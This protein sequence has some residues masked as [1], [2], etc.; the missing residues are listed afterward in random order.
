MNELFYTDL[1]PNA[2]VKS[3]IS[4]KHCTLETL[5]DSPEFTN[6]TLL[7]M[8][9]THSDNISFISSVPSTNTIANCDALITTI[10]K[11]ILSVKTADCLPIL[12]YH[13]YPLIAAIHAGRE[14]TKK[15][16]LFKT[17]SE[18]KKTTKSLNNLEIWFG[19]H[20]CGN[21]YEIN[22]SPKKTFN[23]LKNNINQIKKLIST[24]NVH[25][26]YQ[27]EC[28][29]KKSDRYHSYRKSGKNAGRLYSIIMIN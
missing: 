20:I 7:K 10:P 26:H 6:K 25:F 8:D 15:E 29:L 13:P 22:K 18:I 12:I 3:A 11:V 4:T 1:I 23:I 27:T 16:I 14:G 5:L 24:E 2:K 17:L 28:T 19:P 9:Q 21:C